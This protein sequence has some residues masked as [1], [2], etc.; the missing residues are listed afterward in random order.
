MMLHLTEPEG[1]A[2]PSP[3]L[4]QVAEA[5]PLVAEVVLVSFPFDPVPAVA[6]VAVPAFA[7]PA[8]MQRTLYSVFESLGDAYSSI[9]SE[10]LST[11]MLLRYVASFSYAVL[12][13]KYVAVQRCW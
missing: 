2:V 3:D 7:P 1:Y 4:V 10:F 12:V 8:L 9:L 11:I 5:D 13:A 6:T